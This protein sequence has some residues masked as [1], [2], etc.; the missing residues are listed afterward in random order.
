MITILISCFLN[1]NQRV[2]LS[3]MIVF[4]FYMTYC[5][6]V[7]GMVTHMISVSQKSEFLVIS[8]L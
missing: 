8:F 4:L 3:L 7:V 1:E 5:R 2:N 6:A